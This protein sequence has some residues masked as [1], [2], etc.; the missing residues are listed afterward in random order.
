MYLALKHVLI[1]IPGQNCTLVFC[2][3]TSCYFYREINGNAFSVICLCVAF[4]VER[5]VFFG[6]KQMTFQSYLSMFI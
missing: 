4:F 3:M 2:K 1:D 5:I 6:I